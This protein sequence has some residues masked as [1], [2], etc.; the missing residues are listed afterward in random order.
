M[1]SIIRS[2]R[3]YPR[4]RRGAVSVVAS[5]ALTVG[6]LV[7]LAGPAAADGMCGTPV[8]S[9]ATTTITCSAGAPAVS[10]SRRPYPVWS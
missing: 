9:G 5:T 2:R 1:S 8:V 3:P 7:A 4:W 6:G 10:P